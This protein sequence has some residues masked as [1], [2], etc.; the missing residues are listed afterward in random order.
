MKRA[1]RLQRGEHAEHAVELAAG[2]LGVEMAADRDRRHVRRAL[3]AREHRAHVVDGDAAAER[4]GARLEPVAH[5][6]VE[7][8]QRQ[9]ADAALGGAADR[10]GLHRSRPTAARHRSRDCASP[11]AA[12]SR[13]HRRA[14]HSF[15]AD[16]LVCGTRGTSAPSACAAC[17]PQRGSS[18]MA[19]AIATM[20]ALPSATIASAC[21]GVTIRPTTR[22]AMPASRL[23]RLGDRH[24]V[25][26]LGRIAGVGGDAAGRHVDE[27][28]AVGLRAPWHRPP[29]RR[30]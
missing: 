15:G 14:G 8:G 26:G 6:P 19:R 9:P 22:V 7:I 13:A 12:R 5:L 30:R 25:A 21:A 10:G 28:E 29:R 18:S 24:V 3:A 11:A 1:Q 4:L 20:S 23:T 16:A 17:Q 2:R 27:V